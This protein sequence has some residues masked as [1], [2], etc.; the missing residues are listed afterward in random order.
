MLGIEVKVGDFIAYEENG[1]FRKEKIISI[2]VDEE[3]KNPIIM[4]NRFWAL[5]KSQVLALHIY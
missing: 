2:Q 1:Q 5:I 3:N 4:E